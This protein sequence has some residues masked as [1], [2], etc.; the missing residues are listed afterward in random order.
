MPYGNKM[1]SS[2]LCQSE[3]PKALGVPCQ[4]P[5]TKT[6]Y[7]SLLLYHHFPI[8]ME[9]PTDRDPSPPLG[10]LS[11]DPRRTHCRILLYWLWGRTRV[12]VRRQGVGHSQC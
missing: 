11:S 7:V 8:L 10:A 5:R 4:G 2:Y 1:W 9:P 6:K 3:I 12:D